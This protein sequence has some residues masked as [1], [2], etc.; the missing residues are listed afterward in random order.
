MFLDV[1]YVLYVQEFQGMGDPIS[2]A[3]E[4][5]EETFLS[6]EEQ[7]ARQNARALRELGQ[8]MGSL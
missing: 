7:R 5:A 6:I 4:R 1:A 3:R 2:V 8:K